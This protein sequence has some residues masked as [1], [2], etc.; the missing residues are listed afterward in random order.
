MDPDYSGGYDS[1]RGG[2]V[3]FTD[4]GG[5]SGT[6]AFTQEF[7]L[8]EDNDDGDRYPDDAFEDGGRYDRDER[9]SFGATPWAGVFPGLDE[10][11]DLTPDND[12][13]RNGVPDWTE[14]F[15][16]Y[17][18]D[19]ADFVYGIDF[20]NN[21]QPDFRENDDEPDYPICKD[22]RG[23]HALMGF[24]DVTSWL[25]RIAAG[26]YDMSEI[27][28]PGEAQAIYARAS[29]GWRPAS[30]LRLELHDDVKLVEDTIRDDV[31]AWEIGD[32]SIVGPNTNSPLNSPEPDPLVMQKSLVNTAFLQ[33]VYQPKTDLQ[34]RAD[35]L[36][37]LNR[38]REIQ[39]DGAVVQE[40]D[41]FSELAM[42]IRG[43]YRYAWQRFG[44]WAGG[45]FAFKEGHRGPAW[46]DRSIR[47]FGPIV[48]ASYEIIEGMS[49][50][51]GM[52]GFPGLPTRF[53]DN[54]DESMDYEERKMV[55]MLN[56]RTDDYQGFI[57]NI[58]T[59]LELHRR[60]YDE[61]EW[62]RDFDT[63]GLFV[64]LILGN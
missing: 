27:A 33:L 3:F 61:G 17:H 57:L 31:F 44:L 45:K 55:F 64:E 1:R 25:K 8:V 6:E 39:E 19:S 43:D 28:G 50:Q 23:F 11:G 26:Y 53:V 35:V 34:L 47:F 52:S 18:S 42:V 14:P 36:H 24:D 59:G 38:Q 20:N 10:D 13:D 5:P 30:G 51:W 63:F 48:R 62:E 4:R 32:T 41:S 22:Q 40:S 29:A 2:T 7:P 12:R 21:A 54:E 49:F 60:D 15:L 37:F 56:G 16:H 9:G 46:A 58:S